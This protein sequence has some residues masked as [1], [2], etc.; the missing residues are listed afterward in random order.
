MP[1]DV[2]I[3]GDLRGKSTIIQEEIGL[4]RVELEEKQGHKGG[5]LMLMVIQELSIL[6]ISLYPDMAFQSSQP[7]ID[8]VHGRY[9]ATHYDSIHE[10]I[11]EPIE[12]IDL[13]TTAA[14]PGGQLTIWQNS[15]DGHLHVGAVD[16]MSGSDL[17][18]PQ[19]ADVW[20]DNLAGTDSITSFTTPALGNY[21]NLVTVS[22]NVLF[23]SG[24]SWSFVGLPNGSIRYLGA[25]N[26]FK[27]TARITYTNSAAVASSDFM[28]FQIY[29]GAPIPS[30]PGSTV[31]AFLAAQGT[32]EW[33]TTIVLLPSD[34][35]AVRISGNNTANTINIQAFSMMI[36]RV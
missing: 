13:V 23:S 36:T 17:T 29:R 8:Q 31:R 4:A 10:S 1:R 9:E 14:N 25:Q 5:R 7:V 6:N 22:N 24:S 21:N 33:S 26:L 28:N 3:D 34:V 35:I 12:R 16:L 11:V 27:I 32:I 18:G 2:F 20:F 30:Q 19:Y 15:A